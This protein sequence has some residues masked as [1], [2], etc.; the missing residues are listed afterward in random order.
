MDLKVWKQMLA[1]QSKR[2]IQQQSQ[3]DSSV[4]ASNGASISDNA[5]PVE[6]KA[7]AKEQPQEQPQS[8]AVAVI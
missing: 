8:D 7:I 2:P 6:T 3:S 1:E 5:K 4:Q